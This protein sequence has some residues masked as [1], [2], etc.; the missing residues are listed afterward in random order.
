[1]IQKY[2]QSENEE[3]KVISKMSEYNSSEDKEKRNKN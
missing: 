1:M 3:A 2:S